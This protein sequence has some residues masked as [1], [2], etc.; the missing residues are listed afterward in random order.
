MILSVNFSHTPTKAF[1][2]L[3]PI[4]KSR[5]IDSFSVPKLIL[6]DLFGL[7]EGIVDKGNSAGE[8]SDLIEYTLG[9]WFKDMGIKKYA[10]YGTDLPANTQRN[11]V[12]FLK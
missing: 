11:I 4:S 10:I 2:L 3:I 1:F 9:Q 7:N 8:D 12:A 5:I 6:L